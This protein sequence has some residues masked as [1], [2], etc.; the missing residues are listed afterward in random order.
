MLRI[1]RVLND[2]GG[3]TLRLEG[4]LLSTWVDEL[5]RACAGRG[6][7]SAT[8][9]ALDLAH[10]TFADAEGARLLADLLSAGA[11]LVACSSFVAE[12]LHGVRS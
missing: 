4:K 3:L 12:L 5:R 9:L 10:L 11:T 2:D 1:T 6:A 7:T 8:P